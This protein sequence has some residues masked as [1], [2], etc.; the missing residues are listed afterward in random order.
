[1][2]TM[3]EIAMKTCMCILLLATQSFPW[4]GTTHRGMTKAA[5]K[6][7]LQLSDTGTA[8][9]LSVKVKY[10]MSIDFFQTIM[11]GMS[12]ELSGLLLS[13]IG[14]IADYGLSKDR[15]QIDATL[16]Y[17][18][19]IELEIITEAGQDPDDFDDQTG[20]FG[21]GKCLVGHMY[22]PN[23]LGFA[24]YMV[25][26]FY[27]KAVASYKAGKWTEA[28]VHIGYASH[29]LV[30]VGLPI[31]AEADFLNQ[32]NIQ[33][34]YNIHSKMEDWIANNW[35]T[36]FQSV[37]DEA[38]KEPLPMC[39]IPATVRSLGLETYQKA[40]EWYKAWDLSAEEG[41]DPTNF[42]PRY[43]DNFID[44]VNEAIYRCVPR[45]SGLF[46]KFKQEVNYGVIAGIKV[47]KK[48]LK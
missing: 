1:M 11:K 12:T 32:K 37:A 7:I 26:Y 14:A 27:K 19:Q 10:D 21:A 17:T 35:K 9:T 48:K 45:M 2:I 31:H 29:Y 18:N 15:Y 39:D 30:D 36:L 44:L 22:A 8:T 4:G 13:G 23:G 43:K 42:G 5:A 6:E 25:D 41:K 16:T 34:Q 38:A 47:Q 28:L 20:I 46:L 33:M 3:K 40:S 24:D